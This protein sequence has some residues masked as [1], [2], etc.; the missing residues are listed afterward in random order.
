M[1]TGRVTFYLNTDGTPSWQ[2]AEFKKLCSLFKSVFIWFN[3]TKG[4][5]ANLEKRL[6]MLSINNRNADVCQIVIE[7]LDS[8]L[9]CMVLT[10]YIAEKF[11]LIATTHNQ[12]RLASYHLLHYP[13]LMADIPIQWHFADTEKLPN[14]SKDTLLTQAAQRVNPLLSEELTRALQERERISATALG[15]H[16]ALPHIM[17]AAITKPAV[18]VQ[19]CKQSIIWRDKPLPAKDTAG[20]KLHNNPHELVV[21][22]LFLPAQSERETLIAYTRFTRWL[23]NDTSQQI[24]LN[25]TDNF[26]TKIIISHV[27]AKYQ[28]E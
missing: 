22:A 28:P 6:S 13:S 2:L 3:I 19:R 15:R 17:H 12:K 26:T 24:I 23:L 16:L 25:N 18:V 14:L 11:I 7:G 10:E 21:I 5:Q 4:K 1:I 27:M 8:E 20:D 9:A